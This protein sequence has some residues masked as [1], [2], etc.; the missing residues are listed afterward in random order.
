MPRSPIPCLVLLLSLAAWPPLGC[1]HPGEEERAK[2]AEGDRADAQT[3]AEVGDS[4]AMVDGAAGPRQHPVGPF[5][6]SLVASEDGAPLD[7]EDFAP[8][9]EC[10]ECHERQWEELEGS[11]HV[12][13]HTDPLYRS[14]AELARG[15][16]ARRSTPT[17]PAATRPRASRRA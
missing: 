17:A 3:G 10:G 12:I 13:A 5:G 4:A 1:A 14:T 6:Y 16:R 2:S 15:K 7:V 8:Y 9:E 11:M